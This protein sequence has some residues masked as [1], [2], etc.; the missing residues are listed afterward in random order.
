MFGELTADPELD[1]EWQS[2]VAAAINNLWDRGLAS[3]AEEKKISIA[4]A[5]R[6][7]QIE[8]DALIAAAIR[9]QGENHL[10]TYMT[11]SRHK[12]LAGYMTV[13]SLVSQWRKTLAAPLRGDQAFRVLLHMTRFGDFGAFPD[14]GLPV[15]EFEKEVIERHV[16]WIRS[17]ANVS[18]SD[19]EEMLKQDQTPR[20]ERK[21]VRWVN[22]SLDTSGVE[23]DW[24]VVKKLAD[25][26]LS[27][28]V[29]ERANVERV[30]EADE[31]CQAVMA[32]VAEGL[33]GKT[34]ESRLFQP[35][36]AQEVYSRLVILPLA[37]T[38]SAFWL[39]E[40]DRTVVCVICSREQD[41]D[42]GTPSYD[43]L[44][45]PLDDEDFLALKAKVQEGG[46]RRMTTTRVIDL[47]DYQDRYVGAN[48]I[49]FQHED[50]TYIQPRG[51]LFG[52]SN[53]EESLHDTILSRLS[54][55]PMIQD[56]EALNNESHPCV[57]RTISWIENNDWTN[58]DSEQGWGVD[59][60]AWAQRVHK[61]G[62]QVLSV[63]LPDVEKTSRALLRFVYGD[64]ELA[65]TIETDGFQAL[66]DADPPMLQDFLQALLA[67]ATTPVNDTQFESMNQTITQIMG[68]LFEL[69]NN[70]WDV[71]SPKA[72]ER[73]ES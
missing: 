44:T 17:M 47:L 54:P 30:P 50:W 72:L 37:Q 22:G 3:Q 25:Q 27:S 16:E 65:K 7:D 4:E 39:C 36:V 60:D 57:Q 62:K 34:N 49:V 42:S 12:Y 8:T 67:T 73:K 59:I 29:G 19:L 14:F 58:V 18:R 48:F 43:L 41:S 61:L 13:R 6:L 20:D 52:L 55:S 9:K 38:A 70:G 51:V 28:L 1:K 23:E 64:S 68:P 69:T 71:V 10:R 32:A 66:A 11:R 5:H 35:G 21:P 63:N 2:P 24:Q 46:P 56:L 26:C 53:V 45:Y 40:K 31:I 15:K 33:T